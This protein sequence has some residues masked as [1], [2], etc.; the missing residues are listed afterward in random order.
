M[1]EKRTDVE[2]GRGGR[3]DGAIARIDIE[4]EFQFHI[5][6][7]T[8]WRKRRQARQSPPI[9]IRITGVALSFGTALHVNDHI[10]FWI[11]YS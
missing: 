9:V 4:N 2:R 7:D 1:A 8:C 5:P 11:N 10:L 3:R 6:K